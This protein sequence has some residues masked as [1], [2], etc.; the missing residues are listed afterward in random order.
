MLSWATWRRL[1]FH[2]AIW[3]CNYSHKAEGSCAGWA[4]ATALC[5]TP[6][7]VFYVSMEVTIIKVSAVMPIIWDIPLV[8]LSVMVAMLGSFAA[9]AHGRHMRESSGR[10]AYMW[11]FDGASSLGLAIWASHF[12][13][14]LAF[15]LPVHVDYEPLLA[16]LS[17]L[18][19]I[20]FA[21]LGFYLLRQPVIGARQIVESGILIG[22][23]IC[24]TQYACMATLRLSPPIIYSPLLI[25]LSVVIAVS[26][27]S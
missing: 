3:R 23:G 9:F 15:H 13:G 20:V 17:I 8:V 19:A 14:I 7:P 2:W 22:V 6:V 21:L 10:S 1:L 24:L 4:S 25:A 12:I 26:T 5:T 16:F 18:P 27:S 11:M